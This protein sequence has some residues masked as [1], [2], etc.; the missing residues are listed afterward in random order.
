MTKKR[1]SDFSISLE[2]PYP[3]SVNHYYARTKQ[4]ACFLTKRAKAYQHEVSWLVRCTKGRANT[5]DFPVAVWIELYPPDNRVRDTDNTQKAIFDALQYSGLIENDKLIQEHHVKRF[6]KVL[7][8]MVNVFIKRLEQ[9]C[10]PAV[11]CDHVLPGI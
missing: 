3:P 10:W 1:C 7:G 5:I 2:L 8:G 4:G 9:S 6:E 11:G